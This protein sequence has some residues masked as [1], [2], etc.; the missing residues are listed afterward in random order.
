MFQNKDEFIHEFATRIIQKYGRSVQESHISE[1]YDILGTMVRDYASIFWKETKD[2]TQQGKHRQVVYFSMEFLLGKMML[3]NLRH[4]GIEAIVRNGLNEMGINLDALLDK[5]NDAG[6][7]NGGLGRLAACFLDSLP[8]LGYPAYGNSIRYE[9]GFFRQ[10]IEQGKQVEVPDQWLTLG[11]VWEIRKPK[12]AVDVTFW[13]RVESYQV[14]NRMMFRLVDAEHVRA[15]PYDMP[16]IGA[17]EKIID[18]LRLWSA[19]PSGEQLPRN[20]DFYTYLSETR[21]LCHGLYPDDSTDAGKMLRLKQQY[22]FVSA[23]LQTYIKDHLRHNPSLDNFP[24][25]YVFQLN[26]THPVLAIPE[27]MRLLMDV[28]QYEWDDAWSI[29]TSMIAYTN[30]TVMKEA[31]EVWPIGFVQTLLPRIYTII[32]EIDRR[33]REKVNNETGNLAKSGTMSIIHDHVIDMSRLAIVGSFRVNGVAQLHTKILCEQVFKDFYELEPYKFVGITNGVTPRRFM[34]YCNPNLSLLIDRA[35][36]IHWREN[37]SC[38]NQFLPFAEDPEYQQAFLEIKHQHKMNLARII[39]ERNGIDVD[40]NSIFDVQIKRLHAYKRQLLNV[41]DII[42]SYLKLKEDPSFH[43]YPRTYIFGAKAAPSYQFAK[44]IIELLHAVSEKIEADPHARKFIRIIFLSNYDVSLAEKIIPAADISEQI[45]TA[46]KEASGT[47]NM[48][49]MMNGA[50]TLGTYDGANVEIYERVGDENMVLFGARVEE[51]EELRAN[52]TYHVNDIL[53]KYPHLQQILDSL[54]NGTFGTRPHAFQLI[55]DEI[56]QKNDEF[57]VLGDFESYQNAQR[58]IEMWYRKR[59][60]WAKRCLI[61]IAHSGYF[62]SDRTI[63][64]YVDLIWKLE[65]IQQLKED[66]L[67]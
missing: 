5:E 33:F 2:A 45:S 9:Y 48:K 10:V 29:V 60:Q 65:P 66:K 22:F 23:G 6:L 3:N 59:A 53:A 63:Q 24:D 36:G 17:G 38:L 56:I 7:G 18:T 62:S 4:L 39:K 35:I 34:Q 28:H 37:A 1:K 30:H 27:L 13:G 46:G 15:V 21:Q 42:S 47:G 55:Y 19:E 44:Q 50:I 49:M 20:K 57:F 58:R 67:L 12:H 64:E 52:G 8:K 61:N 43:P 25:R 14:G 40:I 32:V 16:M 41:F 51:L 11:N 26:D 31:L 54:V